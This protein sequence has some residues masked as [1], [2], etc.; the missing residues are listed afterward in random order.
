[1]QRPYS[2]RGKLVFDLL[3]F[4]VRNNIEY[5]DIK[6]DEDFL[7]DATSFDDIMLPGATYID[8]DK[9]AD[10]IELPARET[11]R[12]DSKHPQMTWITMKQLQ[13]Q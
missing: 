7:L 8:D 13:F 10:N 3:D 4:F 9:E 5:K 6:V 2:V 12:L 1:M 11:T